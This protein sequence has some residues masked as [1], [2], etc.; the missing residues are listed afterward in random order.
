[1][2][3]Y[4]NMTKEQ[5]LEEEAKLRQV[6][7]EYQGKGLQLD[8]SRGKPS[9]EQLDLAMELLNALDTETVMKAENGLDVRNYGGLDGIPEA[10]RLMADMM[11]V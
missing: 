6:Y 11:D 5:L 10:K 9:P 2:Q 8:M 3:A 7:Q 1:M 4:A